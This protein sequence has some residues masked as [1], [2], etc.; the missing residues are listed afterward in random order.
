MEQ[1][2]KQFTACDKLAANLA[3]NGILDRFDEL[4]FDITEKED[5]IK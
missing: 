3:A 1:I 5:E 4:G 2:I